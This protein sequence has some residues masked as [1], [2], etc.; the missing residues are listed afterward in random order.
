MLNTIHNIFFL[1]AFPSHLHER[2]MRFL[3]QPNQL[4]G[5]E[6]PELVL[7]LA[8]SEFDRIVLRAVR[9][10]K[11]N[12]EAEL[13]HLFLGLVR[14]MSGQIV[15]KETNLIVSVFVPQFLEPLFELWHVD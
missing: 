6:R 12:T 11:H 13:L 7:E 14:F 8:E 15:Q 9:H 4:L 2:L 1:Y 3:S 5:P 10:I